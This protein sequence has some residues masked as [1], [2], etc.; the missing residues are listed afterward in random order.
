MHYSR[1]RLM[2]SVVYVTT[3]TYATAN[4]QWVRPASP[5]VSSSETKPCQFSSVQLR[6]CVRVLIVETI[7]MAGNNC[8]WRESS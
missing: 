8:M 6:R 3:L 4:D 7:Y 1:H 5:L 2:A